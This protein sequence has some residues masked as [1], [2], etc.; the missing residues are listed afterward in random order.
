MRLRS[1]NVKPCVGGG[2]GDADTSTGTGECLQTFTDFR[3]N[4]Q[5]CISR[6]E[7]YF[8]GKSFLF[9]TTFSRLSFP[10]CIRHLMPASVWF[11]SVWFG[12]V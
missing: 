2:D 8:Y 11:G 5:T 12:L 9:I 1:V 6:N 3:M 10:H 4:T 7:I